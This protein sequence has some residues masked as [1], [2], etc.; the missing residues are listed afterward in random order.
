[1]FPY[2]DYFP[3]VVAE[4]SE[5]AEIALP[6]SLYFFSPIG[7]KAIS[8]QVKAIT[9]PEVPVD[10]DGDPFCRK[11]NVGTSREIF[12]MLAE[13]KSSAMKF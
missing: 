12:Y 5:V 8:S 2:S 6:I 1:M 9:V 10:K 11:H 3:A 13:P 4:S 7:W